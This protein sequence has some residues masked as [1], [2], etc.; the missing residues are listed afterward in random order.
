MA[1]IGAQDFLP[2]SRQDMQ[3]RGWQELDIIIVSGDAYIDHPSFAASVIGRSLESKGYRVGIIPQPSITN[4]D[5]ISALGHPR[6]MWGVTSGNMDSMVNH[7]T[8]QKKLRSEDAYSPDGQIG[9][10]PDRAVLRYTNLI[11]QFSK[12]KPIIIGGIE[13]S[14]RRI[15][16]YD[17]W[18]DKVR[19]SILID[20]KAD[21]LVYG[22][23]ETIIQEIADKLNAGFPI[24]SL[25]DIKGTVTVLTEIDES[26]A[27]EL[28][29][30]ASTC[31]DKS[32]FLKLTQIFQ[33]NYS[34]SIIYQK[35]D[36]R[37]IK[38]NLPADTPHS[39]DLDD[40]YSLPFVRDV[41]PIYKN[42]TLKA[43]EQIRDSITAHRGCGGGCNFCAIGYHQGKK[44]ASRSPKSI[45]EEVENLSQKAYFHGT[46]SDLG[47]PS[48][49][50]YGMSC[51]LPQGLVCKR[52]SCLYP[53]ICPNFDSNHDYYLKLLD[54]VN[55]L[56]GVKNLFIASGIRF[57]LA[58][59][60]PKFIKTITKR[61]IGGHLKLAP[62]HSVPKVLKLMNKPNIDLYEDFSKQFL[63]FSR[64][65]DK[66]QQIIPYIIV[67]H[68]GTDTKDAIKLALYLKKHNLQLEQVQEFYP[69][70]M[71]PSTA[72]YY[73]EKDISTGNKIFVAKGRN[74]RLQKALVQWFIPSN[75]KYV[76][77]ALK[78]Q[79]MLNLLDEF[80]PKSSAKK[81]KNSKFSPQ[82]KGK[83][84]KQTKKR[85]QKK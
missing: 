24:E 16:H 85:K 6:L 30:D 80:Y 8:A 55:C 74:I 58:L 3:A 67:G 62:E 4:L 17:Y 40:I 75:K 18:S 65:V 29:P 1:K 66:K 42:K 81:S 48:A 27:Y 64:Q 41:H 60:S 2:I 33:N 52:S 25:Q 51:K 11:K 21:M 84:Y 38:H 69:T 53:S 61:Y 71:T 78:S 70:P 15:S 39:Q 20:S 59:K 46:I 43:W 68:P 72:M 73:T 7:Y 44:V 63:H 47:G 34:S 22:M 19:N 49:N 82:D 12:D 28:L 76:I 50:M 37:Y 26:Q 10:R 13:A 79:G 54:K 5:D 35:Y 56:P 83:E 23:G 14:M 31:S 57:D 45:I 32:N 9:L 36:K 77:E